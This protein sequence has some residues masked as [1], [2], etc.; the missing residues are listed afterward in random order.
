MELDRRR[1]KSSHSSKRLASFKT[2]LEKAGGKL[3][4]E[5]YTMGQYDGDGLFVTYSF[6]KQNA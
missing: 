5:Y 6:A 1:N 4:Y 2:E 3:I